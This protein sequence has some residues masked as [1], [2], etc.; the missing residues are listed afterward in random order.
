MGGRYGIGSHAS[1]FPNEA[2]VYVSEVWR[3]NE[4]SQ[5]IER[6]DGTMGM[7]IRREDCDLIEFLEEAR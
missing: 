7:L 4:Y 3:L 5:F 6:V 2:D 1:S